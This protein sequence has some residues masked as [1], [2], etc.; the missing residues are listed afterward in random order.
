M[1]QP[2]RR[3]VAVDLR[4]ILVIILWVM[5]KASPLRLKDGIQVRAKVWCFL[6]QKSAG[7]SQLQVHFTVS[8]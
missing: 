2:F 8:H 3:V 6:R 7:M 4:R 5:A 1:D